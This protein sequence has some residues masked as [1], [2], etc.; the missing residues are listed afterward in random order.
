MTKL[1]SSSRGGEGGLRDTSTSGSS[2]PQRLDPNFPRCWGG[3]LPV[4]T[5]PQNPHLPY[6]TQALFTRR[7]ETLCLKCTSNCRP[8]V[9]EV[10]T[11]YFKHIQRKPSLK[12]ILFQ[13]TPPEKRNNP[14]TDI[15]FAQYIMSISN[16]PSN[17]LAK[18]FQEDV[19]PFLQ[20][21][22]EN[23]LYKPILENEK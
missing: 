22:V 3:L 19:G 4:A 13:Q 6:Y 17:E 14:V 11:L 8:F 7:I 20:A 1:Y 23:N 21:S 16:Q 10:E 5:V 15:Q 12:H 18:N 9:A 2:P